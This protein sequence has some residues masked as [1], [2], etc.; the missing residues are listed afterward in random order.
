MNILGESKVYIAN[1]RRTA[2]IMK[3]Y[4]IKMKK[5]LGQNFLMDTN[6]L[7]K[8]VTTAELT[9]Q[10]TVIEIGPGIGAL[11][12]FLALH[13]KQ[14]YAFEIDQRFITILED[15]LSDYDNVQVVHQD[16]LEVDFSA[17]EYQEL[18]QAKDLVVVANLPYYITTPIIMGL[19][20]SGLPF[21][22]LVMMMQK[23]VAQRMIAQPQTKD[24]GSLSIAIQNTMEAELSFIVPRTVFNPPPNVDSGVLTLTRR[25]SPLVPVEDTAAFEQFV[26][27]CFTQR[28]KTLWNNLRNYYGKEQ[29]ELLQVALDKSQINPSQRAEE[30]TIDDFY[31]LYQAFNALN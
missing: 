30:L 5:S 2:E 10:T 14:V 12:E 21:R 25:M 19:I 22:K 15:T 4:Q 17:L 1:P 31:A 9:D 27:V 24:Y 23:E 13:S 28:R 7:R 26:Q 16:I 18:C 8:M 11:T 29:S 20:T 6:I 3:Q